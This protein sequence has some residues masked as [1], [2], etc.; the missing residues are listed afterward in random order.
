VVRV[1]RDLL[2]AQLI[3]SV[4]QRGYFVTN[5]LPPDSEA[6][7]TRAVRRMIDAA[8]EG[9]AGHGLGLPAFLQLVIEQVRQH[10]QAPRQLAV[11]GHRDASLA[12]RV[13]C[14]ARALAGLP[15]KVIGL[16]FQELQARNGSMLP[17][18][19]ASVTWFVVPVGETR[20]AAALLRPHAHRIV[21]MTR[22]LRPDVREFI[23]RQPESTRFG[24]IAGSD[25]LIG[26]VLTMIQRLHPLRVEPIVTSIEHPRE[27]ERVLATADA[28]ILGSYAHREL[29]D[30]LPPGKPSVQLSYLPSEAALRRLRSMV[31]ADAGGN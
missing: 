4:P 1:Y 16:S 27:V 5:G 17:T 2:D 7:A 15:V 23:A 18:D 13:D 8:I 24:I 31:A 19:L 29:R 6:P 14:V 9:A 10:Q 30:R 25:V 22:A 21:P 3:K 26:R 28:F 11:V 20:E 12:E